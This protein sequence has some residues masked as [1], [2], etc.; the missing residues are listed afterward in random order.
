MFQL[1]N[2]LP[3]IL[4]CLWTAVSLHGQNPDLPITQESPKQTMLVH[5]NY[6]QEE[7]YDPAKAARTLAGVPDSMDASKTAV[8]L[9]QILDAKVYVRIGTLPDD[10]NYM[11]T[12][13][14]E[15][16]YIPFPVELPQVYLE[17]RN[18]KWYYSQ[19]TVGAIPNLHK[20]LYPF[21]SDFLISLFPKFGQKKIFGLAIWQ[22]TGIF[23]MLSIGVVIFIILNFLLKNLFR[24][25]SKFKIDPNLVPIETINQLARYASVILVLRFFKIFQPS[26]LLPPQAADVAN[27][28]TWVFTTLMVLFILLKVVDILVLYIRRVTSSTESRLDDQLVPIIK[29]LLQ[30]LIIGAVVIQVFRAFNIDITALIAGLS[31]GGLALAL[32]AKD[33]AQNLFGSITLFLDRPFQIGDWVNFEDVDGTVEEIGVRATR[34]RTFANSLIYVPNGKL[35]NMNIN[36]Y[37]LRHF[38]RFK[39]HISITYDTPPD[40]I[41]KYVEGLRGIVSAHPKTRKDYFEIH[42]N[43]FSGSS[44]DILFYIFFNVPG[45]SDELKARQEIMLASIRLAEELGI[46][47][48]FP[49]SSIY[50]EKLPG[51]PESD[52]PVDAGKSEQKLQTFLDQYK[53]SLSPS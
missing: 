32:A 28:T 27:K 17:K 38:R 41:E 48:A 3:L 2:S 44:L 9:K 43:Q 40:L 37:G 19:E 24:R 18:G 33:T 35:A 20:N 31:I 15:S 12:V 29:T 39:T 22:Y 51:Q 25:L 5:L 6:L 53:Q 47:F 4:V 21:G 16:I 10:P 1:R 34:I 26:L 36:N 46:S 49:S 8:L 23:I 14:N 30:L 7:S 52:H 42:L 11:D 50:V 45:W 13:S